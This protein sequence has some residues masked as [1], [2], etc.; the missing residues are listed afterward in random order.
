MGGQSSADTTF[1]VY[2]NWTNGYATVDSVDC[3]VCARSRARHA[4][5]LPATLQW[6]GPFPTV[7]RA[8]AVA[9]IKRLLRKR[10]RSCK[11]ERGF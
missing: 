7:T 4:D 1:W 5:C 6:L 3:H 11:R 2:V 8:W 9:N 10:R